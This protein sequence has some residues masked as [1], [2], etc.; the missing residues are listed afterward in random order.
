[1]DGPRSLGGGGG[2]GGMSGLRGIVGSRYTR[3]YLVYKGQ[4]YPIPSHWNAFLFVFLITKIEHIST[5]SLVFHSII[6]TARVAKVMFLHFSIILSTL[7]GICL[8]R[9]VC[10]LGVCPPRGVYPLG[11]CTFRQTP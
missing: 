6:I 1:M 11:V 9:G 3:S 4:V 7:G 10:L 5:Y 2:G 8:L